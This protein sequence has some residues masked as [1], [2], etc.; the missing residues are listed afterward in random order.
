MA[1]SLNMSE[2]IEIALR[3]NDEYNADCYT[4][5]KPLYQKALEQGEDRMEWEMRSD[6]RNALA[7]CYHHL[8]E[9]QKAA[10]LNEGTLQLSEWTPTCGLS[11]EDKADIRYELARNLSAVFESNPR[12]KTKLERAV[13]LYKQN[14]QVLKGSSHTGIITDTCLLY[15][16]PSPRD[17]LLSRMPSSA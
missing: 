15:T 8:A 11:I 12:D 9:Y 17:G 4:G 5:A 16:S 1:G 2:V 6:V 14:L 7:K 10:D 3:G 13:A